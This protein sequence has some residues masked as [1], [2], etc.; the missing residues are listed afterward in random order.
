M[1]LSGK[2]SRKLKREGEHH[3]PVQLGGNLPCPRDIKRSLDVVLKQRW[4]ILKKK[5]ATKLSPDS[6]FSPQ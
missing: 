2:R 6:K 3:H 1:P 5:I 4:M